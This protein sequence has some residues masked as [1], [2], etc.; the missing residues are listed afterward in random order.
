MH[1]GTQAEVELLGRSL[2]LRE[3]F[4]G[5]LEAA[6]LLLKYFDLLRTVSELREEA[7][8]VRPARDEAVEA[9]E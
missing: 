9:K 8:S 5:G 4:Y 1:K 3:L 7:W 6:N 2:R